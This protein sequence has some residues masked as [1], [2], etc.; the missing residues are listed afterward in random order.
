MPYHDL[1]LKVI[2]ISDDTGRIN[3]MWGVAIG[4]SLL[5][6][7][8]SYCNI[9]WEA[10]F[11]RKKM[12]RVANNADEFPCPGCIQKTLTLDEK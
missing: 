5:S 1:S 10:N 7:F 9:L 8:C 2:R 6:Y 11:P 12:I 3:T 4:D